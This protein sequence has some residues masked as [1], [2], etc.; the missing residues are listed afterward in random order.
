MLVHIPFSLYTL[1]ISSNSHQFLDLRSLGLNF[2]S[3]RSSSLPRFI[4][5][6]WNLRLYLWHTEFYLQILFLLENTP[7][8]K[9]QI[10]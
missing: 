9:D 2:L 3:Y 7:H 10:S 8:G 4:V 6:H 5:K 1:E